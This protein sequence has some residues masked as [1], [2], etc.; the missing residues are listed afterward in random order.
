DTTRYV[1]PAAPPRPAV[2]EKDQRASRCNES[3]CGSR[4]RNSTVRSA[5]GMRPSP[6]IRTRD[7]PSRSE[8]ASRSTRV[9]PS[10][11]RAAHS[12]LRETTSALPLR[13]VTTGKPSRYEGTLTPRTSTVSPV[14]VALACAAG[15]GAGGSATSSTGVEAHPASASTARTAATSVK[16]FTG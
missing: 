5:S 14:L 16:D 2:Q 11:G 15:A 8:S 9:T 10:D 4:A 7:G 12:V 6:A 1:L 13:P 3:A